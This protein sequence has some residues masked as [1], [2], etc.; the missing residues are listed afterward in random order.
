MQ[1]F[2]Y[3]QSSMPPPEPKGNLLNGKRPFETFT[4]IW[5]IA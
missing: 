2:S 5:L 3:E 1:N 4:P